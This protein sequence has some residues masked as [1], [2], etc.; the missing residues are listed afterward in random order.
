MRARYRKK[1]RK[2]ARPS[3]AAT[4]I[5]LEKKSHRTKKELAIRKQSEA[6]G[7][8]G[9][10]LKESPEVKADEDAHRE[11]LHVKTLMNKIGKNDDIY[12]NA[13][14]RYCMMMSECKGY[15]TL[16][17]EFVEQLNELREKQSE[18]VEEESNGAY[19]K[20]LRDM[21]SNI[22]DVDAKQNQKRQMLLT[23]EKEFSMTLA[24]SLRSTQ[25]KPETKAD[26]LKRGFANGL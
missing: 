3:K 5:E 12:S 26:G 17:K 2:M 23:L 14:N 8:T 11:F 13:I 15:D 7:L 10:K 25:K 4:V 19:Y 21:Q 1:G 24:A 18:I 9:R 6:A 22:L 16:R 20:M